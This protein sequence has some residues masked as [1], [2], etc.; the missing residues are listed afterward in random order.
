MC[1]LN[2]LKREVRYRGKVRP[3]MP[4]EC[5]SKLS[6]RFLKDVWKFNKK[7]HVRIETFLK[8]AGHVKVVQFRNYRQV[9]EFLERI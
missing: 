2:I 3:D 9:R 7:N 5:V 6:F 1:V 4:D 8:E